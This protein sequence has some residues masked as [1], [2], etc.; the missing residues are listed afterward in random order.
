MDATER[1]LPPGAADLSV[2][3][4]KTGAAVLA[5]FTGLNKFQHDKAIQD[6][7]HS[8]DREI[9]VRDLLPRDAD[10]AVAERVDGF[11]VRCF[12]EVNRFDHFAFRPHVSGVQY[13][14]LP[15]ELL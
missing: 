8:Q 10:P 4:E 7:L 13:I 14:P 15:P 12:P 9:A 6:S 11:R 2:T 1:L 3:D 5:C